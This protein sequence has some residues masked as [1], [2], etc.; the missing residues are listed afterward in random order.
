VHHLFGSV[1]GLALLG[2]AVAAA[3][4]LWAAAAPPATSTVAPGAVRLP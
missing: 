1:R 3:V 4:A 2:G